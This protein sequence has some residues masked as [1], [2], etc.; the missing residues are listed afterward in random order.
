[1][2][3]ADAG[4]GVSQIGA[5]DMKR[6]FGLSRVRDEK[7]VIVKRRINPWVNCIHTLVGAGYE[8]MQVLILEYTDEE[9]SDVD[10]PAE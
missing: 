1:M 5:G 2:A 7:G 4:R 8:T 9:D 3:G 10:E 6:I